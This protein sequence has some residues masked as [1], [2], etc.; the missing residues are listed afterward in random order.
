MRE[1]GSGGPR[2][3]LRIAL[4]GIPLLAVV[5]GTVA[6]ASPK[7]PAAGTASKISKLVAASAAIDAVSP[8]VANELPTVSNDNPAVDYP[9]TLNGCPT[10][11][12]CTF[13]DLKS[14]KRLVI[15][16]DSHAQMWIPA[17]NRIGAAEKLKVSVLYLAR[18]PAATLDVWLTI[19]NQDYTACNSER[20]AWITAINKIHPVTV[21]LADHTNGVFTGASGGTQTFTS[22]AWQTGMETTIVD[23]RPSKAKIAVL[24]DSVTYDRSP[25]LCLADSPD[26]T[27]TCDAANP[28]PDRPG[29]QA[30]ELAAAKAEKVLY[31]DPTKWLCTATLCS[32]IVGNFIVYYDAY[33]LSCTYAAYLSGV[34][35]TAL[36]K[37]L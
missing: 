10:L 15:L 34:L 4:V 21:L 9:K 26:A 22:A 11:S 8:T 23:L 14:K 37:V 7:L 2:R 1:G 17:L 13:G 36:R 32:P 18:C 24:G 35:Q 6:A 5:I 19:Y 3:S 12:S 29:Q 31:V 28:N 33:H 25:N 30:A 16:G 27:Q 20:T